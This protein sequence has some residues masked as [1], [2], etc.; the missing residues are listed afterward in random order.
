MRFTRWKM[1]SQIRRRVFSVEI[2][3]RTVQSRFPYSTY[4][5]CVWIPAQR[6]SIVHV[7]NTR[8][9]V[10]HKCR[11]TRWPRYVRRTYVLFARGPNVNRQVSNY[12]VDRV[13]PPTRRAVRVCARVLRHET[14]GW[15]RQTKHFKRFSRFRTTPWTNVRTN[16]NSSR[17]NRTYVDI[18]PIRDIFVSLPRRRYD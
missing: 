14:I 13:R 17:Y 10:I 4:R 16:P 3:L 9:Y 6:T 15:V 5:D 8:C 7:V 11:R 2:D 12:A 18:R 1:S